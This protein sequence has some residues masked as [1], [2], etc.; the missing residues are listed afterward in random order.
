MAAPTAIVYDG[1]RIIP[2][3]R[4]SF[5]RNHRRSG[6]MSSIG[7]EHQ[8]TLTGT[9]VGCKGWDF[10]G[11]DPEFYTGS[12]YP[13]DSSL[14]TC[15]KFNNLVLM[16]EQL[17]DL[18]NVNGDYGWFEIFNCDGE[19]P[20]RW[21]ARTLSVD[22]GEGS[23]T[24]I[25]Q[26]TIVLGLQTDYE[27]DD[28]LHIDHAE[29]W[30]VQ[31]DEENGGIYTLS[32]T[33]STQ[34]EE[35]SHTT[36][37]TED[38]W[39]IAKTWI[40]TR[41]VGSD[42][43]GGA[44]S[45][46]KNSYI[47][48]VEGFYLSG[49]TAY[50]YTVGK[51]LDEFNGTYSITETWTLA[52]HPVFR[53]WNVTYNDPR[54]DYT[55]VTVS[56]EFRSLLNRTTSTEI[57]PTNGDAAI[58]AFNIWEGIGG[59]WAEAHQSYIERGGC[60]SLGT[61]PVNKS[62]TIVDESRGDG[63]ETY[64]VATRTV[65]FSF[66][67]S[68]SDS[69]AEVSIN[70]TVNQSLFNDCETTISISGNIQ[71][72]ECCVNTKL[73]N[74]QIA[75]ASLTSCSTEADAI[76]ATLGGTK[77]LTQTRYI[78]TENEQRG[79]IDFSC[80]FTDEF[81]GLEIKEERTSIGWT[82]GD[83]KS[84][85]ESKNTYSV[86][87]SIKVSC[88]GDMPEAPA[89]NTFDCDGDEC[90]V[91]KRTNVTKDEKNK[92]VTY[93]YEWDNDC[94][95]GLVEITVDTAR[96]PMDC[97]HTHTTV[98][99]SVQGIGCTSEAMLTNAEAAIAAIDPDE[100]APINSCK[101][102]ERENTNKTRGTIQKTI[103]YVNECDATVA[104][105][106]TE[107]YDNSDCAKQSLSIDGEIK[108]SCFAEGGGMAAAE[109]LFLDYGADEFGDSLCLVS[110]RI[111]KNDKDAIIRFNYEYRTCED[112]GY[113][114]TQVITVKTDEQT[115]GSEITISGTVTPFCDKDGVDSQT[116][117]GAAAWAT[118]EPTLETAADDE[119]SSP[120]YAFD[121][122]STSVSTNQNNGQIQY[123]YV[124][125]CQE[126]CSDLDGTLNQ[127]VIINR[128]RP[129][130]VVAVVPILGR[131]CGPVVQP[132]MTKTVEKWTVSIDLLYPKQ[133]GCDYSQP[134]GLSG[135]IASIISSIGYCPT[136]S[137][138]YTERDT[139]SW[140]PRLGRYTRNITYIC[141]CCV[142]SLICSFECV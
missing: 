36:S 116:T 40:D 70:R 88:D 91:L 53:T 114:H 39:S 17:R 85:G 42:Y 119:C 86:D 94:G 77:D 115:C 82:C 107:S 104:I 11:G 3:P 131:T 65:Q 46:I 12:D 92:T 73:T 59:P 108:G 50:D 7:T 22:F 95:P 141:E 128:E 15:D 123:T 66:E 30:N 122:R 69:T 20:R 112:D 126:M 10:S 102:S 45:T 29:S 110:S 25:A 16:Q 121:R 32:H 55:N 34:S 142:E 129:A 58:E 130:D 89:P 79:T 44:P 41:L 21:K 106:T 117:I 133:C 83:L 27:T 52:K 138:T 33:L 109:T 124:Y 54:D 47:F 105:T 23:W 136:A 61:C 127:S 43:T 139:E 111:S 100:Y 48:G 6:D 120:A 1:N 75:L 137:S 97:G 84:D 2:A 8:V 63:T 9:L 4:L 31:F 18:F 14:A 51:S 37:N 24:D 28:D 118:I 134:T 5:N 72:H 76:Y 96:G 87:G 35:F 80:E 67:F 103:T 71:G 13:A 19:T 74:A 93:N 132:K 60:L 99:L 90:C 57:T 113:D 81:E 135:H 64:G 68:D 62:I 101:L 38:G 56:G 26:Y 78:Y 98:G 140:N 125:Q 49:Y